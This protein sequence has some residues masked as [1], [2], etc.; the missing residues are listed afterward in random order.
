[1]YFLKKLKSDLAKEISKKLNAKVLA[2]DFEYPP[3]NIGGDLAL[4]LFKIAKKLEEIAL[5]DDFFIVPLSDM[6]KNSLLMFQISG[7]EVFLL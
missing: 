6:I 3:K 1:M 7:L 4:P 5:S 2:S